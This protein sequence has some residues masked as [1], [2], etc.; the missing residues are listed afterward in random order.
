MTTMRGTRAT[1]E[2]TAAMLA[3]HEREKVAESDIERRRLTTI[4]KTATAGKATNGIRYTCLYPERHQTAVYIPCQDCVTSSPAP[5]AGL[6]EGDGASWS[7]RKYGDENY[8]VLDHFGNVVATGIKTDTTAEAI[9]LA[10]PIHAALVR[11]LEDELA[12][13]RTWQK[14]RDFDIHDLRE[15]FAISVDKIEQALRQARGGK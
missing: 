3:D 5:D 14:A 13:L 11:A 10:V 9:A 4:T 8:Q 6:R 12:A 2:E 15:G 1:E 7:Y